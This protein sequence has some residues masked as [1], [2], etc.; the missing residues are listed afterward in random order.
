MMAAD[1]SHPVGPGNPADDEPPRKESTVR[2]VKSE[3]MQGLADD[4]VERYQHHFIHTIERHLD[5]FDRPVT[6]LDLACGTGASTL[7]LFQRL[8]PGSRVVGI[9]EER[10]ELKLFHEQL[11]RQQRRVVFPRKEKRDRMPFAANV[12]DVA[13]AAL[14]REQLRPTRPTVRA[15]LRV[16]RPGGLLLLAVPLRDAFGK[17]LKAI[18]PGLTGHEDNPAFG[19]LMAEPPDLMGADAWYADMQRCGAVEVEVHTD[20][21]ETRLTLPLSRQALFTRHLLPVWLGADDTLQAHALRLLDE[22][23]K[24]PLTVEVRIGCIRGRRGMSDIE[25]SLTP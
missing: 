25:D 1:T 9:S 10:T 14:S 13:W 24:D 18:G 20:T 23:V 16:L 6:A 15:A 5:P 7:A 12:F 17:L 19:A 8:P 4:P 22:T 11:S 21:I 2:I 3:L